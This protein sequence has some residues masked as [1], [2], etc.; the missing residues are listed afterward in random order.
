M[1]RTRM[2]APFGFPHIH[3]HQALENCMV[4]RRIASSSPS[5]QNSQLQLPTFGWAE[6]SHV[7]LAFSCSVQFCI[8]LFFHCHDLGEPWINT[9]AHFLALSHSFPSIS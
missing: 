6:K 8:S 9:W 3:F 7:C 2:A 5:L 1:C 4:N